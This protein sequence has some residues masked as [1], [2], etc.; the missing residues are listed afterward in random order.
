MSI[1]SANELTA[2]A[3]QVD[4]RKIG[5]PSLGS[6]AD[7]KLSSVPKLE[8]LDIGFTIRPTEYN[9]VV[10]PAVVETK[11]GS[12]LL[13]DSTREKLEDTAQVGRIV[14]VSPIAFNYA[15]WSETGSLPPQVGDMVWFAKY[16]GGQFT[17]VDGR[18]Y[19]I[20]KDR[21]VAFIIEGED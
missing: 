10:A 8:D 2:T 18:V 4:S 3:S 13:A 14:A 5:V 20:I 17:G 1:S 15:Q 12:I 11:V 19:R 16:A 9:V 6:L 21:D 7:I